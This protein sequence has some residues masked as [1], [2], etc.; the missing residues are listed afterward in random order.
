MDSP[1]VAKRNKNRMH[2]LLVL[3]QLRPWALHTLLVVCAKLHLVLFTNSKP[4][5]SLV[6]PEVQSLYYF[7][8]I[9]TARKAWLILSSWQGWGLC[10]A[11][12]IDNS[13]TLS[14]SGWWG[15]WWKGASPLVHWGECT[16]G[17]W[18]WPCHMGNYS[19]CEIREDTQEG[20]LPPTGLAREESSRVSQDVDILP[21]S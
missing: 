6:A 15:W 14:E 4:D 5:A 19:T 9:R 7:P 18:K 21:C 3:P 10:V 13:N 17:S 16:D 8:W 20:S 1:F 12:W 11:L 2:F